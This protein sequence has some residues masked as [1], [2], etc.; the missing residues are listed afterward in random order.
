[1][2]YRTVGKEVSVSF[3]EKKSEFIGH[4]KPVQTEQ[5]ARE[6]LEQKRSAL[7]LSIQKIIFR[8]FSYLRFHNRQ[9]HDEQ[10]QPRHISAFTDAARPVYLLFFWLCIPMLL[11]RREAQ[12]LFSGRDTQFA[13]N[14]FVVVFQCIFGNTQDLCDLFGA[15]TC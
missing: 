13:V 10:N 3:I 11:Q 12:H 14:V 9:N 1:M 2:E 7:N 5:E 6:F 4:I 15:L 8:A